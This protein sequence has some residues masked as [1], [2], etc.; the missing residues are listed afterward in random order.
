MMRKNSYLIL[1]G[2]TGGHVIPAVNFGNFIIEKG[3]KCYLLIDERG[4]KYASSFKGQI[5]I[6]NSSHFSYNFFGKIRAVIFHII[7][8]L[9][10]LKYI[11]I[12]RPRSCVAFGSYATFTPL[13]VLVFF[14]IFGLTKIF[15]HE[16]NSVM[17][18]VNI[19]FTSF[20]NKIFLNF[21]KTLKIK[22]NFKKKSFVV[23]LPFDHKF[24]LI[25]RDI[26]INNKKYIRVFVSGGSQ[27]AVSLNKIMINL[28]NKFPRN[29]LNQIQFSIQCPDSQK[30]EISNFF[31]K[32]SV[33]YELRSFFDEFI[34]K[35]Y[36]S[37]VLIT[38]A[39]AGTVNDVISTKTPAIFVPLPSSANDHQFY[40]ANFLKQKKAAL[41]IEQRDLNSQESLSIVIEL[42]SN[43]KKQNDLIKNLKKIK[44][45]DTNQLIF[46]YLNDTK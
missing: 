31:D 9:Q 41:L 37:D 1:S 39:G 26:K 43:I 44:S 6:I 25:N 10:S 13:L 36:E 8:F 7:G 29:I 14:R 23:G 28:F 4:E 40:N 12:I 34:K 38:R 27:G 21:E 19:L 45:I 22:N 11:L 17:G 35:L 18:K 20:A 24:K 5:K 2:G 15:L 42:I 3:Y 32:L 46:K 16:Q 30:K 33:K